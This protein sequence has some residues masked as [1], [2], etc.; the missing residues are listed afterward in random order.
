MYIVFAGS[1]DFAVEILKSL[2]YN[3]NILCVITQPDKPVGR[4]KILTPC[5]VKVYAQ[6]NN[7]NIYQPEKINSQ[8]SLDYITSFKPDFF[9]VA[10]YGQKIGKTLLEW[11]KPINVHGSIL[12]NL[13]GAAPIQYSIINGYKET[14]VTTMLMDEGMDT[15]DMLLKS[16]CPID[17]NDNYETLS[18][19][20]ANLGSTLIIETL[21]DFNNITPIKQDESKVTKTW[22]IKKEETE[23]DFNKSALEVHNLIRGLFPKP[24]GIC[25]FNG[26]VFKLLVSEF[27]ENETCHNGGEVLNISKKGIEIGCTKGS[28]LIK[29][30][31]PEGKKPMDAMSFVNG[32]HLKIGDMF[33]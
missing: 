9:V 6:E 24:N 32:S 16:T 23:I 33:E 29:E 30:L 7:L 2:N 31:Q 3:Y 25:A 11:S 13:R 19:K 12:P 26:K 21:N 27:I 20:L 18:N 5:P 10:A 15:G 28:L 4:K 8:E 1:S 17:I 14:G 22:T